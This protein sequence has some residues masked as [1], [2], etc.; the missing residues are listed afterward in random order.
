[1]GRGATDEAKS[2]LATA[3]GV[4][5]SKGNVM[6]RKGTSLAE[7][8]PIDCSR[9]FTEGF[10]EPQQTLTIGCRLQSTK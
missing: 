2:M 3:L 1:M 4:Y 9:H 5:E 10:S 7:T 6:S 8:S